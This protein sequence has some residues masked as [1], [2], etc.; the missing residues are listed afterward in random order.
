MALKITTEPRE[1]RQLGVQIEVDPARVEQEL[2][3]AARKAASEYRIPGFR[4][5]KAPYHVIVQMVGLPTLYSQFVDELGQEIYQQAIEQ[6]KLEPYATA[7]LEDIEL[8]PLTYKLLVPL[9][10]EVTLGDYRSLRVEEEPVTVSDEEINARLES[11]QEQHSGWQE[12]TRPSQYGDLMNINVRS[13]IID[14]D[15]SAE[16]TV[17]LDE[18]DWDV[19]PDQENPMEPP[20][21]DE[22]LLGLEPGAQKEFELSWPADGQS[23]YAGK[24]AR[25]SVT[26]NKLQ[27][28]EKPELND[29]F[30]QLVGPD[31]ATLE[32]LKTSIRTTLE[33]QQA[34]TQRATYAEKVLDALLEQ[35]TL[36][37]PPVVVEDQM[38][39]MIGEFERQLRQLGI[40]S[41]ESYLRQT[42]GGTLEEYRERLRPDAQRLAEQNL[43]ISEVLRLEKLSVSDEEIEERIK[44]MM[45][46]TSEEEMDSEATQ[47]IAEMLR[48]GS[49]RAILDSQILREKALDL[50]LAIARG[51]DVP[52]P[53]ADEPD[54]ASADAESASEGEPASE[55]PS[56]ESA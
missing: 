14:E 36:N 16:E 5:G 23:I 33:E 38:D 25:F 27:A 26:V 34:A 35:S 37:Y 8:E 41:L 39:S 18:T 47:S 6:E 3:K 1:N 52:P 51:E 19:T 30:A 29:E 32:D 13:V 15:P 17:V 20:G 40:E 28:Y 31:Y 46:D 53:P 49:G 55:A 44:T 21:F 22:A 48:S 10:P 7:S 24:T 56:G 12:V 9:E 54:S 50:L 4:K 2:R 45:G 43:L 42:G 11:Y